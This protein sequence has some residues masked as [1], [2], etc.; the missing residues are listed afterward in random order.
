MDRR[1]FRVWDELG[2]L[3]L[4]ERYEKCF[5]DNKGAVYVMLQGK[6]CR[7]TRKNY[8]I[9]Y[10]T[11]ILDKNNIEI[12]EN[13]VV[14]NKRGRVF[15]VK[16][17]NNSFKLDDGVGLVDFKNTEYSLVNEIEIIS[18][19]RNYKKISLK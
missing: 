19:V 4:E 9:E 8:S 13:D 5:I 12:F 3:Y 17:Y 15:V 16:F 18:N 1:G 14:R 7:L 11:N 2:E 6:L 10:S